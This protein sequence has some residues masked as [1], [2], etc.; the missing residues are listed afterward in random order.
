M[1]L[2]GI[3]LLAYYHAVNKSDELDKSML[4]KNDPLIGL[5]PTPSMK[6]H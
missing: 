1:L 3:G 2:M 4:P 5:N 6:A